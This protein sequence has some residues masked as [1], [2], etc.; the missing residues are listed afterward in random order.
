MIRMREKRCTRR[1]ICPSVTLSAQ[2]P[3]RTDL[4]LNPDIR[5][6]S[7]TAYNLIHDTAPTG[8]W[9]IRELELLNTSPWCFDCPPPTP[10]LV[11]VLTFSARRTNLFLRSSL[12]QQQPTACRISCLQDECFGPM[13]HSLFVYFVLSF[14]AVNYLVGRSCGQCARNLRRTSP[15]DIHI[16]CRKTTAFLYCCNLQLLL[17]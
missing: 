3:T 7:P 5:S 9:N 13:L 17:V 2:D 1:R 14:L 16:H 6:Y 8:I 11:H 4:G 15:S 10:A 12:H